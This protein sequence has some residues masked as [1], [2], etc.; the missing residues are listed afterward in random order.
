MSERMVDRVAYAIA[1]ASTSDWSDEHHWCMNY[2]N[3]ERFIAIARAAIEAMR[4][5]TE[6]VVFGARFWANSPAFDH[7]ADIYKC[8]IHEALRDV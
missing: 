4:E 6:S 7:A 3:R 8:M 2:K 5:P 1:K